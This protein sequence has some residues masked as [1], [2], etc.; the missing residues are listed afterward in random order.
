MTKM[1]G[2]QHVDT[3]EQLLVLYNKILSMVADPERPTEAGT[4]AL[5]LG[6]TYLQAAQVHATL[7][8]TSA[9]AANIRRSGYLPDLAKEWVG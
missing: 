3:A 5:R 1:T 2:Q 6:G 9:T 8:L 7:A 4:A